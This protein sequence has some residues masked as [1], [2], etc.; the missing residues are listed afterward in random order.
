MVGIIID[1]KPTGSALTKGARLGLYMPV[2][3]CTENTR[4]NILSKPTTTRRKIK[5]KMDPS[6]QWHAEFYASLLDK[7]KRAADESLFTRKRSHFVRK[8]LVQFIVKTTRSLGLSPGTMHLS[9]SLLD[10]S[11]DLGNLRL[12]A[13][14]C[15]RLASKVAPD[16][17]RNDVPSPLKLQ[18]VTGINAEPSEFAD[19]ECKILQHINWN[20]CRFVSAYDFIDFWFQNP[21]NIFFSMALKQKAIAICD[22]FMT[23]EKFRLYNPSVVASA[24]LAAARILI[25]ELP[26][27]S[28]KLHRMTGYFYIH[29]SNCTND[30]NHHLQMNVAPSTPISDNPVPHPD[31]DNRLL[32]TRFWNRPKAQGSPRNSVHSLLFSSFMSRHALKYLLK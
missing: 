20:P 26:A 32:Q 1:Q 28:P 7:E 13:V 15:L 23:D 11:P 31:D 8:Y 22:S 12:M 30:I 19:M 27:W 29:I 3:L 25:N 24:C 6:T 10:A 4:L 2:Q 16:S 5:M 18:H 21:H 14:T 17:C 9:I